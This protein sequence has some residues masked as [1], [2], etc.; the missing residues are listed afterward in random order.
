MKKLNF[1]NYSL[2]VKLI[3]IILSTSVTALTLAFGIFSYYDSIEFKNTK[4]KRLSILAETIALNLTA[5]ISFHDDI[6]A[7]EVINTLKVDPKI[8]QAGLFFA[9]NT[10]FTHIAFDT[11]IYT[12]FELLEALDTT[13]YINTYNLIITKPI[14]DEVETDKLIG[15]FYIITDTKDIKERMDQLIILLLSIIFVSS[16]VALFIANILQKIVSSP[17]ARLANTMKKISDTRRFDYR[18]KEERNDEIGTLMDSFNDLLSQIYQSNEALVLAKE[19]AEHSAKV[20]EEFLANMSHEIRTPMNGIVGMKELLEETGLDKEQMSYLSNISISVENLLVIINDILDYSKIEAGKMSI[21]YMHFDLF[22]LLGNLEDTLKLRA[23]TK[24]LNLIFKVYPNVPRYV[25]GDKV[26]VSQVLIN[27]IGNAL[28]FTNKGSVEVHV[29]LE[30]VKTHTQTIRFDV[31]DTGIGIPKA[32]I[33]TIFQSFNQAKASTTREYGGSGL[34]LT[35]CKQLVELQ[36]GNINAESTE[37][38]GSRFTFTIIFK[39]S[40]DQ[41]NHTDAIVVE[42]VPEYTFN[43]KI[44]ILVAE[45]NK[46]NQILLNKILLKFDFNTKIV[47]DGSMVLDALKKDTYDILLLDIH[48][49][50]L[51]G[52]GTAKAIRNS[53]EVY[54]E[55]PIIALTAAAIIDEQEK[56]KAYGMNEYISKPFKQKHLLE[57]IYK[58]IKT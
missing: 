37:G 57:T 22:K 20:K 13:F 35:I 17:L 44:N 9:D 50:V 10:S 15:R 11:I 19:H 53:D 12:E 52:Y 14:F 18:I 23:E 42:E 33:E 43:R 5:S 39:K 2:R 48:M 24:N 29:D 58:Y 40:K 26:R 56:C 55:I 1:K 16:I 34:G 36:G 49:P 51:D 38:E 54:K 27:L 3:F 6:S 47:D 45:D 32:K 4:I 25:T 46:I 7:N 21:E 31:I 30:G 28:K 41:H 8:K